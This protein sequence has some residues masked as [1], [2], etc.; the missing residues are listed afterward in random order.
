MIKSIWVLT[1]PFV[2]I[3][4]NADKEKL[5]TK[6][7]HTFKQIHFLLDQFDDTSGAYHLFK[8]SRLK[9]I[10]S[11]NDQAN[12]CVSKQYNTWY[13]L[14]YKNNQRYTLSSL[15]Q[16]NPT[17]YLIPLYLGHLARDNDQKEK[18]LSYYQNYIELKK[19][20]IEP[21]V[22]E[23]IQSGGLKPYISKW[24]QHLNSN[25]EI[26][27]EKFK[28]IFFGIKDKKIF[29][30]TYTNKLNFLQFSK[31]H[32][33]D[34]T[35][36]ASYHVGNFYIPKNGDYTLSLNTSRAKAC[37]VIIDEMLLSERTSFQKQFRFSKGFHKIEIELLN[38][39][40]TFELSFAFTPHQKRYAIQDIQ[41]SLPKKPFKIYLVNYQPNYQGEST[42]NGGFKIKKESKSPELLLEDS[43][44]PIILILQST[45]QV[46]WKIKNSKQVHTVIIGK[47]SSLSDTFSADT[48]IK[49][50]YHAEENF[51]AKE[52]LPDLQK[53]QCVSSSFFLCDDS[54]LRQSEKIEKLFNHRVNAYTYSTKDLFLV[55]QEIVKENI[56]KDFKQKLDHEK[57]LCQETKL[58]KIL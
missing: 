4:A 21:Q 19:T 40:T 8:E 7:D 17:N 38:K 52:F 51:R 50:L 44:Q 39:D 27:K 34:T 11:K 43:D 9:S 36:T 58:D 6:V 23:Y 29:K 20:D 24:A 47:H 14:L 55:P 33:H 22:Q 16:S 32:G 37:R 41:R 10:F 13:Y 42:S 49:H 35:D 1:L 18:A 5:C 54:F 25:Q 15:S 53:C 56:L 31:V 45:T 46:N 48:T 28:N 26:P 57:K 30:T 3:F 2:F 12:Q